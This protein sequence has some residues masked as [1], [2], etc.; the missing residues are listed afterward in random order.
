[1]RM[2]QRKGIAVL[3]VS[4]VAGA[5]ISLPVPAPVSAAPQQ[6]APTYTVVSIGVSPA[7]ARDM[8]RSLDARM[9]RL[10]NGSAFVFDD[11]AALAPPTIASP[12]S[13]GG[14][15]EDDGS[16]I[17]D[18]VVDVAALKAI[19]L[20][21][22]KKAISQVK[23]AVPRP[24]GVDTQWSAFINDATRVGIDG[25]TKESY[26]LTVTV[27]GRSSLDGVPLIGPGSL[28]RMIF[29]DQSHVAVALVNQ[30]SVKR[31]ENV[32][33]LTPSQARERCREISKTVTADARPEL[34]Y[35]AP[36]LAS[37][38]TRLVP[39]YAC[40]QGALGTTSQSQG[41]PSGVIIPAA[42]ELLPTF[43]ISGTRSG[44]SIS[45][46]IN[47]TKV[48]PPVSITWAAD[49]IDLPDTDSPKVAGVVT[50]PLDESVD[51]RS[52]L[53]TASVTD[54]NGIVSSATL[55]FPKDGSAVGTSA[56]GTAGLD[57]ATVEIAE[58]FT[59]FRG[60]ATALNE[61][62]GLPLVMRY[63]RNAGSNDFDYFQFGDAHERAF[64]SDHLPWGRDGLEDYGLDSYDLVAYIGHGAGVEFSATGIPYIT[65]EEPTLYRQAISP[66]QITLGDLDTEF[67]ALLSCLTLEGTA[68]Q[69]ANAWHPAF[70][71]LHV[72]NGFTT[73]MSTYNRADTMSYNFGNALF[74]EYIPNVVSLVQRTRNPARARTTG[75]VASAW[76]WGAL[77]SQPSGSG[78]RTLAP[79]TASG[80]TTIGDRY[81][82]QGSRG[83]DIPHELI[84][85]YWV[86]SYRV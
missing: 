46:S 35:Y 67:L 25:S 30:F 18:E 9:Q 75:T 42:P 45:A 69:A 40:P 72:L 20:P 53:L 65:Y 52:P 61:A 71:G 10:P 47:L 80:V 21:T 11:L 77:T 55:E 41:D 19:Q 3:A 57:F 70:D 49:G 76:A 60:N 86:T 24:T 34:V 50:P 6:T 82:G 58:Q 63:N 66:L 28:Q 56:A 16:P 74:G 36:P 62:M 83:H 78:V 37:S 33:I 68:G 12:E 29:G 39:H 2:L 54:G 1:M 22:P 7:Q 8:G 31:G 17:V 4:A 64:R 51:A 84:Q 59:A 44:T 15:D 48:T 26:P 23:A 73:L 85:T 14:A 32:P 13:T 27:T 43:D 81:W 38:I 79:V 5:T